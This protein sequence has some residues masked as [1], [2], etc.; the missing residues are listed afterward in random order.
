MQEYNFDTWCQEEQNLPPA[1]CDKRLPQDDA[2]FHAFVDKME[3]YETQDLN[4][5]ARERNL[6]RTLSTDPTV[7]QT[8]PAANQPIRTPQ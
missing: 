4:R 3:Q 5:K 6:D 8:D 1:R 2:A 7:N